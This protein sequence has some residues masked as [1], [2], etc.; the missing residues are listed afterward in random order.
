MEGN[1]NDLV[2]NLALTEKKKE[3][4]MVK[5]ENKLKK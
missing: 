3:K 1:I 5:E 4:S 2:K